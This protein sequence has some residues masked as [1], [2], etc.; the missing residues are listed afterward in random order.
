MTQDSA[1]QLVLYGAAWCPDCRRSKSFLAEQ[2]VAY[3]YVDLEANPEE[4]VTVER[5]NDGKMIIPTIV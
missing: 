2:R 1:P 5:Y 4:Q 3:D